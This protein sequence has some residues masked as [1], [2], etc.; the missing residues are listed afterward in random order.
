MA[1]GHGHRRGGSVTEHGSGSGF[2]IEAATVEE[3][4][5]L[6][7]EREEDQAASGVRRSPLRR[8]V[9]IARMLERRASR[10]GYPKITRHVVAAFA[11]GGDVVC[12]RR[13]TSNAVEL[14]EIAS[15]TE[16]RQR[17]VY[18]EMR[19]E[20]GRS[21]EEANLDVPLYEG[22]LRRSA[23]PERNR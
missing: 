20:I 18:D 3:F 11:H 8:A 15:S 5:W 10:F 14:P 2:E 22:Y 17:A 1:A 13:T 12:C 21:I 19:S 6:L 9:F 23:E 7:K 16:E 4:L